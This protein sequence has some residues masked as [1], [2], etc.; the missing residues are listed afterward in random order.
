MN[1]PIAHASTP[2]EDL[3]NYR[4]SHSSAE[5]GL[6]YQ[7]TYQRGYYYY[8]W[9]YIERVLLHG[10]LAAGAAEGSRTCLDFA[11]GTG[12]IAQVASGVFE[13]VVGVDVSESMLAI[14]RAETAGVELVL[15]DITRERLEE[16]FD[17]V[18]AFRFFTNAEE[19]LRSEALVAIH[20]SLQDGGTLIA[21]IHVN[22]SSL[23]GAYYRLRNWLLGTTTARTMG[24]REFQSLLN[25]HGFEIVATRWY[26]FLPR[27]GWHFPWLA[28]YLM[29]P[30]DWFCTRRYLVPQSMAS[31]FV[32]VCRKR[33][34]AANLKIAA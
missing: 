32:V 3:E 27:P 13:R 15:R 31:C 26:S 25:E 4:Q 12:R 5:Y 34:A 29:K 17:V 23:V 1:Q 10:L 11:C 30:V 19:T 14:A 33:G 9:T 2:P 16:R 18:T 7:D 8:Q 22:R 28:K 24:H 21:N 6:R 20:G